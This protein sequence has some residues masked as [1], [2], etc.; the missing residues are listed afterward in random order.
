MAVREATAST[1]L[2]LL[3]GCWPKPPADY[4]LSFSY[5]CGSACRQRT[6][7]LAKERSLTI[8][9]LSNKKFTYMT[10]LSGRG[11]GGARMSGMP[12]S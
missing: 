10:N 5:P 4:D 2:R 6:H 8:L 1:Q 7:M 9:L 3:K 12:E 11:G